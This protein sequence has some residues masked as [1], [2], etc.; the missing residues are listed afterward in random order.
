MIFQ[1]EQL[2]PNQF[3]PLISDFKGKNLPSEQIESDYNNT[4]NHPNNYFTAP[5]SWYEYFYTTSRKNMLLLSK[6]IDNIVRIKPPFNRYALLSLFQMVRKIH[7][8]KE[9]CI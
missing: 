3:T 9:Q 4:L 5:K 6:G 7:N 1:I 2:H 8:V